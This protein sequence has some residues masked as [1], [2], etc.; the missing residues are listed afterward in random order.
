MAEQEKRRDEIDKR[1]QWKLE[2]LY[3]T[4]D[5]WEADFQ[6]V[7][8][9][10]LE[11]ESFKGH[12]AEDPAKAIKAYFEGH[13]TL[14]RMY[15]FAHMHKDEDNANTTFQA[16]TDRAESLSVET[17]AAASFL[18]PELLAMEESA[19]QALMKDPALSD[20]DVYLHTLIRNKPHTLPAEQEKLLAMTGEMASAPQNI[21]SM[22]TK[23]D[24]KFPDIRNEKG[25]EVSLTEAGYGT[26]IRSSD[27]RV[28]KDAFAS[29]FETYTNFGATIAAAYSGS[30]KGDLFAA[31]ARGFETAVDASLFP[32]EIPLSVYDN[33]ISVIHE[34]LPAL[35]EYI[36]LRKPVMNLDEI[37]L[38]DLYASMVEDYDMKV[39]YPEAYRMVMEGLSPLGAEYQ[40]VLNGAYE[41][42]WIDVYSS[43]AKSSGAYSWGAYGVHPYVLLNHR[44][45]LDSAMTIAH[46][47]GHAMHSYLSNLHQPAP[48]ANYTL[49]A[50]EVAST[51]N[52][53]ILMTKLMEHYA[54]NRK[55][56][57]YLCNHLLE[58]FRTTVFRQTMFAEFERISHRMAE[59]GEALTKE[60]LSK[61]YLTLNQKYYGQHC[62][63]DELIAVEWMRIPHFYRAFYVYKYATGFSAAVFLANRILTEGEPAVKDYYKFLSAGGSLPPIEALKLAGVDMSSPE[64]IRSAM[65]VFKQTTERLAKLL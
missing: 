59:E 63:V 62:V 20:F 13:L 15:A 52:E 60:A 23:V 51:C 2:D 26:F 41:D 29:L 37:H 45:D 34:S 40:K 65:R 10:V 9:S 25:E 61:A 6:K 30:V 28:R 35:N 54:D 49:F 58:Q 46:E 36:A 32:D 8:T 18:E 38:Y 19:L 11:F 48:K 50:A 4:L 3:P 31:R 56:L 7:K 43:K 17:E 5:M 57:A 16:L 64:P 42:G 47:M 39:P 14:E 44:D 33:L 24:M 27:R 55:A 22:L 53:I 21:F 12:V 1:W